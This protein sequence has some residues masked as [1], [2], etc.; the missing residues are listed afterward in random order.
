[1]IFSTM[2]I[3]N[4]VMYTQENMDQEFRAFDIYLIFGS[5][6]LGFVS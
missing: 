5:F 1:M 2:K 6:I 4:K 3:K